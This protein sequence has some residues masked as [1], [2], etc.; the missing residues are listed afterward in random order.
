MMAAQLVHVTQDQAAGAHTSH[1]GNGSTD[2]LG[3][4]CWGR[5]VGVDMLGLKEPY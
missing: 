1:E 4:T 2:M 5:H 3:S